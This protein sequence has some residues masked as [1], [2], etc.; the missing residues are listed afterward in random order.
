[1]P[2]GSSRLPWR[3]PAA[4]IEHAQAVPLGEHPLLG[5][6]QLAERA[7]DAAEAEQAEPDLARAGRVGLLVEAGE[8]D[9]D[10]AGG[11][12]RRGCAGAHRTERERSPTAATRRSSS[13]SVVYGASP[14]RTRPPRSCR[15]SSSTRRCGVEVAVPGEE[16]ARAERAADLAGLEPVERERDGGRARAALRR[17]VERDAGDAGELLAQ[18]LRE[19]L[20]VGLA[21]QHAGDDRPAPALQ[22]GGE[23]VLHHRRGAARRGRR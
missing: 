1:M 16:A 10:V 4:V 9:A 21:G 11:A 12:G 7:R 22:A 19:R 15:P 2:A 14:T 3:V 5:G 23:A 6:E 18:P 8:G 13:P 17:P 20:L